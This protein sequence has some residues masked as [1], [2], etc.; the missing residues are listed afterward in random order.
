MTI[1][2]PRLTSVSSTSQP[3]LLLA[4]DEYFSDPAP[5]TLAKLYD[6]INSLDLSSLPTFSR[7]EKLVLRSSER[8]DL[9]ADRFATSTSAPAQDQTRPFVD[10]KTSL[11]SMRSHNA[12]TGRASP[13]PFGSKEGGGVRDTHVWDTSVAFGKVDIPI[14]W[15]L[16]EWE[17]EVGEVSSRQAQL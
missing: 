17:D 9:F 3:I 10:R 2:R 14:R 6:A 7:A 4:L 8:K 1:C 5:A 11:A 12:P 16:D 13:F 15:P